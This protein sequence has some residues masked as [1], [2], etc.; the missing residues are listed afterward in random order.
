M[1]TSRE[2]TERKI[3]WI[4]ANAERLKPV[5]DFWHKEVKL[6]DPTLLSDIRKDLNYACRT[7]DYDIW[8]AIKKTY[9]LL[10]KVKENG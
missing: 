1:H 9:G 7:T 5:I 3:E 4:E 6:K 2:Q 10:F 8:W